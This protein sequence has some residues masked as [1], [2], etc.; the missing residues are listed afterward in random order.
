MGSPYRQAI[1]DLAFFRFAVL[2]WAVHIGTPKFRRWVVDHLPWPRL[3]KAKDLVETLHKTS[4]EL[5]ES[6]KRALEEGGEEYS[7]GSGKDI[8]SIVLK[9]N[10][11]ADSEGKMSEEELLAQLSYALLYV[12][13][14]HIS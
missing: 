9:E 10:S 2:P 1:A 8:I 6:K 4:K 12:G 13:V 11:V 7:E 5:F 14:A 3:Q